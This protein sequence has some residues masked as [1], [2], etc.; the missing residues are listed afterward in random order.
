MPKNDS[1]L[2]VIAPRRLR[3]PDAAKYIAS[4]NWFME[5][6][7]RESQIPFQRCGKYKVVDVRDLDEW[8]DR[9]RRK[10]LR[11]RSDIGSGPGEQ[12][13]RH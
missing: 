5:E 13:P 1:P 11:E 7:L 3:I 12:K 4:T 6:L 9:D 2:F 10:A 8:V